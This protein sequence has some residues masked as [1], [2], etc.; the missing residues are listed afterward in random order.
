MREIKFEFGFINHAP[1]KFTLNQI[2]AG[3]PLRMAYGGAGEI[4]YKRQYTGLKDKNG[5]EIYEG[6]I[7]RVD[8]K[9]VRYE[10]YNAAVEWVEKASCFEFGSGVTSEVNWSHE[11]IGNIHENP[12]LLE[13]K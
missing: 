3:E 4:T 13:A 9:D 6:D 1:K 8:H 11:V 10:M 5:V 2:V 7:C 12:E